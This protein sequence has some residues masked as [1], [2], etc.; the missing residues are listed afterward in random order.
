MK[1]SILKITVLTLLASSI[2]LACKKEN[3]VTS[4]NNSRQCAEC[5]TDY[6]SINDINN[7]N[8][9][10]F[11]LFDNYV[12]S[13]GNIHTVYP[14][15]GNKTTNG[16]YSPM[17]MSTGQIKLDYSTLNYLTFTP[18][19]ITF[20]VVGYSRGYYSFHANIPHYN[21]QLPGTPLIV[22]KVDDLPTALAPYGYS[23]QVYHYNDVTHLGLN[24]TD[25]MSLGKLDSVVITGNDV[26]QITIGADFIETEIRNICVYER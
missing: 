4:E 25:T 17:G 6:L 1:T 20:T 13:N 23:T 15:I 21:I 2:L 22:S 12:D 26:S 24:P 10:G 7:N 5:F 16:Y 14:Y 8:T 3:S 19:K 11:L 18:K 9:N